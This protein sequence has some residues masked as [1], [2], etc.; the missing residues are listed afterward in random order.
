MAHWIGRKYRLGMPVVLQRYHRDGAF[1]SGERRLTMPTD[2]KSQ[3]YRQRFFK[4]NPYL[5]RERR[6]DREE[7][8][9][10]T[11]WTGYESRPGTADLRLIIMERDGYVCQRCGATVTLS[12]GQLDHIRPVRRFKRAIDANV[13]WNLWTLCI[14]CHRRKTEADRQTESRVR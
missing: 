7:L 10:E 14:R 5:V 2:F 11:H 4:P 8:P 13:E 6:L 9:A 12:S 3:A 1:Y